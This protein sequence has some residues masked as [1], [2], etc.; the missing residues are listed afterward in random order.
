MVGGCAQVAA[1]DQEVA[2]IAREIGVAEIVV[3]VGAGGQQRDARV[4][5][6]GERGEARLHALEERREAQ[7]VA[8]FEQVAGDL[9]VNDAVGECIAD[10]RRGLGVIVDDAPAAVRLACEIEGVELQIARRRLDAMARCQEGRIGEDE[11][12]RDEAFAQEALLAVDVGENGVHEPR[13][14]QDGRS[15]GPANRRS[16]E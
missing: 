6:A 1:F 11:G 7:A 16:P 5:A 2:E 14:L 12:R 13:A 9:R 8:S 15:R 3:V 4:A 10:A